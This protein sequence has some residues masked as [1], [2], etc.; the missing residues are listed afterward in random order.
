MINNWKVKI[1]DPGYKLTYDV[2]IFRD[3][4]DGKTEMVDGTIVIRGDKPI[5]PSLELNKEQLQEFADSLNGMGIS[6]RKE[7]IQGKLEATEKHLEDMRKLV[8]KN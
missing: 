6:P 3:T 7:F 1:I 2:F 5:K 8:F 4:C